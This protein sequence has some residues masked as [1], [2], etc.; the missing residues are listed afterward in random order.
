[1]GKK[2][3][4]K[5]LL[6][7]LFIVIPLTNVTYAS[8]LPPD[9]EGLVFEG[10]LKFDLDGL[11][12]LGPIGYPLK[13]LG[14]LEVSEGGLIIGDLSINAQKTSINKDWDGAYI[15][16]NWDGTY[17]G[18]WVFDPVGCECDFELG[19]LTSLELFQDSGNVNLTLNGLNK[20]LGKEGE[21]MLIS[22][23]LDG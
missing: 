15:N 16:K 4:I 21:Q 9:S 12:F 20:V 18:H 19:L 11:Y 23:S 22:G 1:M 10:K 5:M 3:L 2:F 13:A 6:L 8:L 14:L 17:I 7:S